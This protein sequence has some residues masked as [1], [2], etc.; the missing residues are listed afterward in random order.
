MLP[1]AFKQK[2]FTGSWF[3]SWPYNHHQ[4]HF[5]ESHGFWAARPDFNFTSFITLL[6]TPLKVKFFIS[7]SQGWIHS[8]QRDSYTQNHIFLLHRQWGVGW[9]LSGTELSVELPQFK[10]SVF[11]DGIYICRYCWSMIVVCNWCDL[12]CCCC[13][14][15]FQC[16]CC[17]CCCCLAHLQC[18]PRCCVVLL[19]CVIDVICVVV[20]V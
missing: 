5:M 10:R 15:H 17:C 19:L 11:F 12:C 1:S 18:R 3:C 9:L 16:C 2:L 4:P 14:A 20:V 13:L 8:I 7:S 6:R